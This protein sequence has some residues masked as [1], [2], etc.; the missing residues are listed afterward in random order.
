VAAQAD[1]GE[2]T[3]AKR[4]AQYRERQRDGKVTAKDAV[5]GD[6]AVTAQELESKSETEHDDEDARART[7]PRKCRTTGITN[8][9]GATQTRTKEPRARNDA[10]G[11]SR[12]S[13]R[14]ARSRA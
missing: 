3:H 14:P 7:V 4:Q 9:Y 5:T 1:E 10:V 12:K 2:A 8:R 6:G 11:T 13:S